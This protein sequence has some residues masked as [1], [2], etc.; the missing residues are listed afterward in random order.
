MKSKRA[1]ITAAFLV[2][3][4]LIFAIILLYQYQNAN[5]EKRT[6]FG[7]R[8]QEIEALEKALNQKGL[9]ADDQAVI[10][11]KLQAL[12]FQVTLQAEGIKQL[13]TMPSEAEAARKSMA[14]PALGYEENRRTGILNNPSVPYPT[15]DFVI[16][17]AWQKIMDGGYI[18]VFAGAL[19]K[20]KNQGVLL[21]TDEAKKASYKILSPEKTGY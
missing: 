20:D 16:S 2:F 12:Y 18:I 21:I 9:S 8:T 11:S 4:L 14:Q 17:N 1:I 7:N 15:S 13:T 5:A 3:T 10:K 19:T 6:Q